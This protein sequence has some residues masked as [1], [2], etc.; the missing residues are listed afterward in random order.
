M[1]DENHF[2][3]RDIERRRLGRLAQ[4]IALKSERRRL[5]E[6]GHPNPE[7]AVQ[8]VWDQP[9]RGYD[10]LS[11]ELDGTPR[12]IEVKAARLSGARLSFFL[13]QNE[14]KQSRSLPNYC[15]YLVLNAQSTNPAVKVIDGTEVTPECLVAVNYSASLC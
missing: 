3:Q 7:D 2:A 11:C 15:F 4:D 8:A 13:T 12:H 9:G 1:L 5:R 14:W 6:A 10:I